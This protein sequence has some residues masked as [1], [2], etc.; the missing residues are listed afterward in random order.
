MSNNFF[1][2]GNLDP[3]VVLRSKTLTTNSELDT[4]NLKFASLS[5]NKAILLYPTKID[6]Y[7]IAGSGTT[8]AI[9]EFL[10]TKAV[11]MSF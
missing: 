1:Y 6:Y 7:R 3:N 11:T 10:F 4:T 9:I 8:T 2:W 5:S